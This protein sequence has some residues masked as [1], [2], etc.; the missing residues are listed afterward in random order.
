MEIA[1]TDS[2][3]VAEKTESD[4]HIAA[5]LAQMAQLLVPGETL[6]AYAVQRRVFAITHRRTI[7]GATSGRLIGMSRGLFGGFGPRDIRWQDLKDA[8]LRVGIFGA[9]LTVISFSNPHLAVA[10]QVVTRAFVGLR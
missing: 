6:E 5:A 8:R 1:M 2:K 3:S 4:P 10:G 7:V 9:D